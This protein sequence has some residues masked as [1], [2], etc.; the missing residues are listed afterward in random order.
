MAS[1]NK[2][3]LMGHLTADPDLKYTPGGTAIAVFT[4]A[5]NRKWKGADQEIK[6]EVDFI[7]C[8]AFGSI[9]ETMSNHLTKG[10]P[11]F[12]E[13]RLAIERWEDKDGGKKSRARVV[14]EKF[15]FI[16]SKPKSGEGASDNEENIPY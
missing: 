12:V 9:A 8:K 2:I 10:N 13:G 11:I 7:D 6:E 5:I 4:V 1:F 16:G 14:V 15:C 3:L